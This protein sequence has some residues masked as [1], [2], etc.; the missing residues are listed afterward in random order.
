MSLPAPPPTAGQLVEKVRQLCISHL[1]DWGGVASGSI[2]VCPV[3]SGLSNEL[4]RAA[5]PEEETHKVLVRFYGADSDF[6]YDRKWEL[7]VLSFFGE[8]GFAPKILAQFEGGRFE[9]WLEARHMKSEDLNSTPGLCLLAHKLL[10]PVLHLLLV[11]FLRLQIPPPG[12]CQRFTAVKILRLEFFFEEVKQIEYLFNIRKLTHEAKQLQGSA[13]GRHWARRVVLGHNDFYDGNVLQSASGE[14][15]LI[16]FEYADYNWAAYDLATLFT[17]LMIDLHAPQCDF[18][19]RP[20]LY[21]SEA[22]RRQV[23]KSYLSS[24]S[25]SSSSSSLPSSSSLAHVDLDSPE[26][27]E[28]LLEVERLTLACHLLW[29]FWGVLRHVTTSSASS[30]STFDYLSYAI[31]RWV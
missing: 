15:H 23:I 11:P 26:V 29:G 8:K 27:S 25:A 10:P 13:L 20:D 19:I 3:A 31:A 12:S 17:E 18:L 1:P 24:S 5:K 16:D 22:R 7:D 14:I 4:F 6:F 2:S 28:F 21:P 9:E 30:S